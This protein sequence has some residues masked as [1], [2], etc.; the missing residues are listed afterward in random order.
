[1]RVAQVAL[2]VPVP[3]LFDYLIPA[4]CEVEPGRRVVVAFRG[5]PAVGLVCGIAAES[6]LSGERLRSIERACDDEPLVPADVLE[7]VRFCSD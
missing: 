1:M 2:D 7:L 5:R 3:T 4:G 6:D